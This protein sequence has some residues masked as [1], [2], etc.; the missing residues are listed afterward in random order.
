MEIHKQGITFVLLLLIFTNCSRKPSLQWIPFSWEG[1]TISGIYIEKAFLNVPVK[2]E[3]LPYEFTMEHIILSFTGIL[4][5]LIS[6]K[7]HL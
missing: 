6:K 5:L 4:L 2:I 3:N 1:D 7:P